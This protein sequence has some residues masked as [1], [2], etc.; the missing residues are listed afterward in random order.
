MIENIGKVKLNLQYYSGQDLYSDGAIEDELLDIVAKYKEDDFDTIIKEK[1]SWP[2]L[3]HLSG[4]RQNI[5][6]W[7]PFKE[8]ANVLEV[9]AGCGAITGAL[10][11]KADRVVALDL[12]KRRSTINA[13]RN[14]EKQNLEIMVGNF[15]DIQ[16]GIQEKFDYIT[17]IGVFEYAESYINEKKPQEVFLEKINKLLKDD[18]KILIAIEN[19]FGLKYFAG[20]KEDHFSRFGEGISG[21]YSTDGVRTFNRDE[22]KKLLDKCGFK[23]YKFY[24][25]YPDYKFPTT[26]YS[27]E[28]MPKAGELTNN[29]RNFDTDRIVLFDETTAFD[30]IIENEKFA[31]YSN[32]FFIE[33]NKKE[34]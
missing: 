29:I 8:N 24:Y 9:G 26:I 32:S 30:S 33:V 18:G 3:Y 27:D 20:C 4:M 22:W 6:T 21:Y 15:N 25:P 11:D 19:R 34:S 31:E 7:Y 5:V 17:L 2:V 14:K 1:N 23:N 12:S 16:S 10:T 13:T 28:Y